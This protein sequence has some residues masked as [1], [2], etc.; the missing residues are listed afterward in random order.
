MFDA[1]RPTFTANRY[2]D[3]FV[4][5]AKADAEDVLCRVTVINRGPDAAPVHVLP[6]LWYSSTTRSKRNDWL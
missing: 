5:Y 3:V 6:H 2:F 4:E 1:L